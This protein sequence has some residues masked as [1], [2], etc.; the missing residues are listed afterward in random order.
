MT[1]NKQNTVICPKCGTPIQTS[2]GINYD[3]SIS[4]NVDAKTDKTITNSINHKAM[5]AQE[6]IEALRK[7]GVN[8]DNLF[9]MRGAD[10]QETI[11]RL[12]NGNL[13]IVPDNDPI[14]QSIVNGGYIPSPKLFRRWVMAQVFHMLATGDFTKALQLKGY[15]YQWKMLIDELHAQA[16]MVDHNDIASYSERNVY[17]NQERVMTIAADYLTQ[18]RAYIKA[19]PRKNCKGA[20]YVTLNRQH[21]FVSRLVD[22]V[23]T[24]LNNALSIIGQAQNAKAL[25]YATLVFYNLAKSIHLKDDF[26]MAPLFKDSYKGA[27]AYFTMK[28]MI[29][30]HGCKFRNEKGQYINVASSLEY[31]ESKTREYAKEG[32]RLFGVLK[33]LINQNGIDI[34]KKIAEWRK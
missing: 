31:L 18:L 6:K 30:F 25:Y 15:K 9:S 14:F 4:V 13:S 34:N 26:K 19:L 11:A 16:K 32:W 28:N 27:G 20:S 21:I 23:Y 33:E 10:G 22:E 2:K 3:V 1:S 8:V 29:L 7:A 12:D 17:F 24:P 5:K